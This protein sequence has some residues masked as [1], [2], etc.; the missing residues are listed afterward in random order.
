MR[1]LLACPVC[2]GS[3]LRPFAMDAWQP[4][5]LHIGQARCAGCGL[6]AAQPQASPDELAAFYEGTYY[7]EHPIDPETH[8]QENVR[9]YPRYE[10][11]LLE[12]LSAGFAPPPGGRVGEIGCG[13]GSLLTVLGARGYETHG[14]ELSPSAVAFCRAK[15]LDVRKGTDFGDEEARYDLVASFQVIEHVLDP[16][17][18]VRRMIAPTRPGGAVVITT[19]NVWTAQYAFVRLGMLL[20]GRLAPYRTSNAHTFVFQGR[21]LERLLRE[22][23]CDVTRSA[24]YRRGPAEGRLAFR[25]Y[26]ETFRA[27]DAWAGGG[28]Y[29]MAVGRRA[30]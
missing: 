24:A 18:F 9:D 8:W 13:H 17:A 14:V 19:E 6:V 5:N 12:R 30:R 20:R 28:E 4:G 10:L 1:P 27:L 2:G 15:A 29:L 26:R 22:E 3:D 7:E 11:P 21:H 25:L 16:R 23:G